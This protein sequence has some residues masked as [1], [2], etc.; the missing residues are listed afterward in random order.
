[1]TQTTRARRLGHKHSMSGLFVFLLIGAYMVFS[2]LL[3][4]IGVQAY[5]G[6]VDRT[7]VNSQVR[8]TVS[9]VA[10]K[11]RAADGMVLL[12]EEQ[13]LTVLTIRD[14]YDEDA[15]ETRIYFNKDESG[16]GALYEQV[17]AADEPFDPD[18]GE[19]VSRV[20]AFSMTQN[21]YLLEL[22]MTTAAGERHWLHLRFRTEKPIFTT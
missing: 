4:L 6:V 7:D 1:M 15:Y 2:L 14:D 10:N 8:T 17:A 21:G 20:H 19:L 3:V 18:L 22:S 13:G 9:Y 12:K 16:Q 11:V 5:K